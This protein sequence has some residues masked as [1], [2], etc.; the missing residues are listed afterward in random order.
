MR[1]LIKKDLFQLKNNMILLITLVIVVGISVIIFF[2]FDPSPLC[3]IFPAIA[4]TI[5]IGGIGKDKSTK[6]EKFSYTFPIKVTDYGKSKYLLYLISTFL[7]L[8]LSIFI[9]IIGKALGND[10]DKA[11]FIASVSLGISVSLMNGA[12]TIPVGLLYEE[13]KIMVLKMTS[14][15]V[16]SMIFVAITFIINIFVPVKTIINYVYVVYVIFGIAIYFS[17]WLLFKNHLV[18]KIEF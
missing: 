15:F 16:S 7:F 2:S 3:V 10:I 5:A 6:W 13:S 11:M 17:S 9:V 1:G 8:L 12:L 18:D 14:L 4:G